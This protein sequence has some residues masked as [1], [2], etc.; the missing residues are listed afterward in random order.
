MG[1]AHKRTNTVPLSLALPQAVSWYWLPVP[2]LSTRAVHR[3]TAPFLQLQLGRPPA[4]CHGRRA[5]DLAPT[6]LVPLRPLPW[7]SPGALSIRPWSSPV[8]PAPSSSHGARTAPLKLKLHHAPPSSSFMS[9][10]HA[11]CSSLA[12][13]Y[14]LPSHPILSAVELPRAR[15]LVPASLSSSIFPPWR[16]TFSHLTCERP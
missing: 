3:N 9:S 15:A 1:Q 13:L 2:L 8:E 4:A 10:P 14:G 12:S 11:A 6:R 5:L 16:S 7:N